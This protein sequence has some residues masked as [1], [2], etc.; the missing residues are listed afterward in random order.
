M[1]TLHAWSALLIFFTQTKSLKASFYCWFW[2]ILE[3]WIFV[4][5]HFQA[6]FWVFFVLEALTTL[7]FS[8][9]CWVGSTPMST[10][11]YSDRSL[12][13]H[14]TVSGMYIPDTCF[15]LA[16]WLGKG[17]VKIAR[18]KESFGNLQQWPAQS[19]AEGVYSTQSGCIPCRCFSC[20][21]GLP[22]GGVIP[23]QKQIDHNQSCSLR[24]TA[25]NY[26]VHFHF[27]KT[28]KY[29]LL[30][31]RFDQRHNYALPTQQE[32]ALNSWHWQQSNI[33]ACCWN[34]HIIVV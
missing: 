6:V 9:N 11:R 31:C 19:Y 34:G 8:S 24:E 29:I 20:I 17:Q 10:A 33:L 16:V 7:R 14:L 26:W 25:V 27:V 21:Q 15:W 1:L 22:P 5:S 4:P 13:C 28:Y 23:G 30:L 2:V 12:V 3:C 18:V 32:R